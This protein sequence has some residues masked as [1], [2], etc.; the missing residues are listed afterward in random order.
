LASAV[1]IAGDSIAGT[2]IAVMAEVSDC[3]ATSFCDCVF[4]RIETMSTMRVSVTTVALTMSATMERSV[5]FM[6]RR[7]AG[8]GL[9]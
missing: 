7:P 2:L 3:T 9:G 5:R 4:C 8:V 6:G 1:P